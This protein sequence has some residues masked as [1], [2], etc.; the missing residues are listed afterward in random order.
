MES[1]GSVNQMEDVEVG[2]LGEEISRG[3]YG[4]ITGKRVH[5]YPTPTK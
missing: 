3:L 1:D 4:D 2:T 5:T